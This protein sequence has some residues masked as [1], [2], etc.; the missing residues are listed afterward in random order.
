MAGWG[1]LVVEGKRKGWGHSP[2]AWPQRAL[3]IQEQFLSWLKPGGAARQ[4]VQLRKRS[5]A[6]RRPLPKNTSRR[7][8]WQHPG[9]TGW[10]AFPANA[11][12]W[13]WA[14]VPGWYGQDST[15]SSGIFCLPP[16]QGAARQNWHMP[17]AQ[18]ILPMNSNL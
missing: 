18:S 9:S 2:S 10:S 8:L 1:E 7:E 3:Q 11:E 12:P 13:T 16:T 15:V 14:E 4:R 5:E 17:L 6:R